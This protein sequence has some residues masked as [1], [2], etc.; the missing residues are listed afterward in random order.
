MRTDLTEKEVAENM[1]ELAIYL[2][3]RNNVT[4][5]DITIRDLHM[6]FEAYQEGSDEE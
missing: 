6:H 2:A 4:D 3:Q 5:I 1:M